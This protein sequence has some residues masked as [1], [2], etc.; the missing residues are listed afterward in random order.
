[1]IPENILLTYTNKLTFMRVVEQVSSI[2]PQSDEERDSAAV[3]AAAHTA[4]QLASVCTTAK[5][6]LCLVLM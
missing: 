2:W 1:M 6:V 5:I 3:F 4:V